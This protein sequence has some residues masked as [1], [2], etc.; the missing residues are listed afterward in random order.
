LKTGCRTADFLRNFTPK[1][2]FNLFGRVSF[3]SLPR[4]VFSPSVDE[5]SVALAPFFESGDEMP[6]QAQ[7]PPKEFF[8]PDHRNRHHQRYTARKPP[9][10]SRVKPKRSAAG[11]RS[12]RI[13]VNFAGRKTASGSKRGGKP[14][15]A[16]GGK[17]SRK[18]KERYKISAGAN[19]LKMSSLRRKSCPLR[20]KISS[21]CNQR[22]LWGLSPR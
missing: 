12:R 15:P 21:R 7:M 1:L 9:A 11:S 2:F 20:Y 17:A 22:W 8:R 10:A 3:A 16:I 4:R 14:I 6:H 19:Y 13:K 18:P 5:L